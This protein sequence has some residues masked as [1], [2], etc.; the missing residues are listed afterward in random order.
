MLLCRFLVTKTCNHLCM[1]AFSPKV[2]NII[3]SSKMLSKSCLLVI[4]RCNL[5]SKIH[6][7]LGLGCVSV[8]WGYCTWI[9]CASDWN[10]ST[11]LSSSSPIRVLTT[12]SRLPMGKK[13]TSS[14]PLICPMRRKCL[15]FVSRGS[16]AKLSCQKSMLGLSYSS[17]AAN[18]VYRKT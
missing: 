17:S 3:K 13:S 16:K 14:L 2:T 1:L 10:V 15:R 5:T 11:I 12:K 18:E 6:Q 4:L 9:L 7:C 8:S